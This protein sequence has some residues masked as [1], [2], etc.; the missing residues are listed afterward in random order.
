MKL[1]NTLMLALAACFSLFAAARGAE[2]SS[3]SGGALF[4]GSAG[5]QT[6]YAQATTSKNPL[7]K[8][9]VFLAGEHFYALLQQTREGGGSLEYQAYANGGASRK[10]RGSFTVQGNV[11]KAA[12]SKGFRLTL[13]ITGSRIQIQYRGLGGKFRAAAE[14]RHF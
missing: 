12:G 7:L 6:Y 8:T 4:T 13:K 10:G 2:L 9:Y 5:I 14:L 3:F 1:R 11:L